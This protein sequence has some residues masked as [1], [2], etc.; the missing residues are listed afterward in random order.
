MIILKDPEAAKSMGLIS[1]KAQI[2]AGTA[3]W[4]SFFSLI[5]QGTAIA[6]AFLFAIVAIWSFGREFSDHTVKELL[7]L[8]TSREATVTAKFVVI[9]VWTLALTLVVFVFSLIVGTMVTIPDWSSELLGDSFVNVMGSTFL[10]MLLLPYVALIASI[11]RGYMPP[12]GWT[13]LMIAFAQIA[14]VTGW[15]DWFPWAVPGLFSGAAGQ[16][17]ELLGMHGYII[18]VIASIIGLAATYY[19]WRTADQ[20]R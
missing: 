7:A 18:V 9:A 12:F 8:P 10:N 3:D 20:T 1:T 19:W 5:T 16:R 15:G 13:L 2:T 14:V 4:P 6:G 17:A 11:G